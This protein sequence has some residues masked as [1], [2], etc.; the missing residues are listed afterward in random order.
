VNPTLRQGDSAIM[1]ERVD[2]SVGYVPEKGSRDLERA[3]RR[4]IR[5]GRAF[6]IASGSPNRV[7]TRPRP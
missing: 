3:C 7:G 6:R 1:Q 5:V 4:V 2:L